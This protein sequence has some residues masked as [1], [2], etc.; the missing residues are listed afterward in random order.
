MVLELCHLEGRQL[1][2]ATN[3]HKEFRHMG[4][5]AHSAWFAVCEVNLPW[6][7]S[8]DHLDPVFVADFLVDKVL[9]CF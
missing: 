9:C 7:F 5:R 1:P 4:N 6:V 2:V 8:L 3:I